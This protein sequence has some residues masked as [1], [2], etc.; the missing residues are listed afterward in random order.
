MLP[1]PLPPPPHMMVAA[2]HQQPCHQQERRTAVCRGLCVH[3]TTA[4][5]TF[6][7]CCCQSICYN[8]TIET[9]T[10]DYDVHKHQQHQ[11]AVELL[12]IQFQLRANWYRRHVPNCETSFLTK[13]FRMTPAAFIIT[14]PC[15]YLEPL[16]ESLRHCTQL[17]GMIGIPITLFTLFFAGHCQKQHSANYNN[18]NGSCFI[19]HIDIKS[20]HTPKHLTEYNHFHVF[21]G[22]FYSI[23]YHAMR[24]QK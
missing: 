16:I 17:N 24:Y 8:V 5:A 11:E 21:Y 12:G 4:M 13:G 2:Q 15:G 7:G 18:R 22:F 23:Q 10:M 19:R 1:P 14:A 20:N 6:W 9:V 3:C